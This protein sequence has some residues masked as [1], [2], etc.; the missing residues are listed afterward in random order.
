MGGTGV[1]DAGQEMPGMMPFRDDGGYAG[2]TAEGFSLRWSEF[3]EEG[4]I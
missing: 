3:H 4:V 1:G 2:L